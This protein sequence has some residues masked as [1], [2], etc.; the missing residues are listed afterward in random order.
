MAY[1]RL[2]SGDYFGSSRIGL[3]LTP[4]NAAHVDD[5]LLQTRL[6]NF[7]MTG[8]IIQIEEHEYNNLKINQKTFGNF[9]LQVVGV[10]T[11]LIIEPVESVLEEPP[12]NPIQFQRHIIWPR[13]K[14]QWVGRG[15]L[16]AEFVDGD[17]TYHTPKDGWTVPVYALGISFQYTGHYPSGTWNISRERV[18]ELIDIIEA[19]N[20]PETEEIWATEE[21]VTEVVR[22]ERDA[23]VAYEQY[24]LSLIQSIQLSQA[25]PNASQVPIS[26]TGEN[27][28]GNNVELALAELA[29]SLYQQ[30]QDIE[31]IELQIQLLLS[32][33]QTILSSVTQTSNRVVVFLDTNSINFSHNVGY[34]PVWQLYKVLNPATVSG[35]VVVNNTNLMGVVAQPHLITN[36]SI[37]FSFPKNHTLVLVLNK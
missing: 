15:N 24:L 30:G 28:E 8:F 6:Y 3:Y 1:I 34:I 9:P 22:A 2:G 32:Q 7:L 5:N 35:G 14:G 31:T 11:P 33:I 19:P 21:W 23:R 13:G 10:H 26:D 17:W 16:I 12:L 29:Q 18:I 37:R 4:H 25:Y 36:Y 27:F 20:D